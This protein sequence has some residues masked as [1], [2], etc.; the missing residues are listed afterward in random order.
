MS[1]IYFY[2]CHCP[3]N[4][5]RTEV[6]NDLCGN[7]P[8]GAETCTRPSMLEIPE[9]CPQCKAE[10]QA[11]GKSGKG[12]SKA[13][14]RAPDRMDGYDEGSSTSAS[15]SLK[16]Y[17]NPDIRSKTDPKGGKDKSKDPKTD[18]KDPKG[19]SK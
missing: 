16:Y 9:D 3:H 18:K 14:S 12:K 2:T 17:P 15:A 11:A 5:K 6:D 1:R 13:D 7:I 19:K 10:A 8:R 4:Y